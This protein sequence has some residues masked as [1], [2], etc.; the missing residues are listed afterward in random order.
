[1]VADLIVHG[2]YDDMYDRHCSYRRGLDGPG[3]QSVLSP[4]GGPILLRWP[5]VA[6]GDLRR[7]R[8][9]LRPAGDRMP[10]DG[11][12]RWRTSSNASAGLHRFRPAAHLSRGRASLAPISRPSGPKERIAGILALGCPIP[13]REVFR[14]DNVG[15]LRDS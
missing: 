4:D 12:S 10:A 13:W 6:P 14:Q 11:A 8:Q 3:A 5:P 15:S 2:E 1:M 7:R 9:R